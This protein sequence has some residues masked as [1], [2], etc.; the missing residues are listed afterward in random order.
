VESGILHLDSLLSHPF[1]PLL[2]L[3]AAGLLLGRLRLAGVSL[4]A[5]GV[6]FVALAA[7]RHGFT[8]PNGAGVVGLILFVYCIG[9]SAGPG[10]FRTFVRRGRIYAQL[11]TALVFTGAAAAVTAALFFGLPADLAAGVFAGALTSTPALAAALE[12]LPPGSAAAVGYG[13]AY[14]FGVVGVVL[15]VQLLPRLLGKSFQQLAAEEAQGSAADPIERV[16]VEVLNPGV[17]GRDLSQLPAIGEANCMV[18]RILV[19]SR[20]AP[21][22]LGRPLAI[23][24]QLLLVG[25]RSRLPGV[26]ELLGKAAENQDFDLDT[27]R[28]RMHVVVSS[29][30]V[31]GKTLAE[32]KPLGTFGVTISRI[33][34]HGV[35]FVPK[36]NDEIEYGDS[37]N[38]VGERKNLERFAAAAGHRSRT[39]DETDLISVAVGLMAGILLGLA[40]VELAGRSFSLGMAGGPLFTGLLLGHFGH[41][42]P[43]KGHIPR[44]ARMLLQEVGLILFLASAGAQAGG[45]LDAALA[46]FGPALLSA[47]C[48]VALLPLALGYLIGR[49][50]FGMGLLESL[51]AICGGLTSTPGLGAISSQTD[52]ETPVISYA[53]AYPAAMILMT[54]AARMLVT[55][56]S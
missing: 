9:L 51:G 2:L 49:K 33:L 52:S 37:L 35:E 41:V 40:S 11:A 48:V 14:P 47:A 4:G 46:Q 23:G 42:G 15:F 56:L 20:L 24:D 16:L 22:A 55:A 25:R 1:L 21:V 10:F 8:L 28:E 32:L 18:S 53:A 3:I 29:P 12:S 54:I 36:P 26:V 6:I 13:V 19:G 34:R 17:A 43:I 39:F 27:E 7:G 38:A 50:I 44:A 31:F 30:Q 45:G 5:S